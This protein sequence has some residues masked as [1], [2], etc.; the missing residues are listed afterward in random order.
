MG[1]RKASCPYMIRPVL[2]EEMNKGALVFYTEN[3]DSPCD[4]HASEEPNMVV[5]HKMNVHGSVVEECQ[6]RTYGPWIVVERKRNVQKNQRSGESH[7]AMDNGKLRQGQRKAESEANF[8]FTAG[9]GG[10][11]FFNSSDRSEEF[12]VATLAGNGLS[13]GV[14][15]VEDDRMDLETLASNSTSLGVGNAEDDRMNLEGGGEV[16]AS[17]EE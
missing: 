11:E 4:T 5:G 12:A 7:A 15:N 10:L 6:E 3:T 17:F 8:K 13:L 16:V 1:H 9:T 2:P 14:G